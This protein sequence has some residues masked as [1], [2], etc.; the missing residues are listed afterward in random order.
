MDSNVFKAILAMDAYNRGYAE[1]IAL[2]SVVN[3]TRIGNALIV[4]QSDT[5]L[6]SDPVQVGFYGIAYQLDGGEKVI[7]YRGTDQAP[8]FWEAL[9]LGD[10]SKFL[11]ADVMN[12]YGLGAGSPTVAAH[13]AEFAV[14]FYHDVVGNEADWRSANVSFTGHSLGGGLAGFV[15]SL[16]NRT[17][18]LFN[19]MD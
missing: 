16:Y 1:G 2:P 10:L 9:L 6:S 3:S 14:K 18:I 19:N 17:G 11:T 15:G 7:S 4:N 8:D 12:G 5:D 13:Q